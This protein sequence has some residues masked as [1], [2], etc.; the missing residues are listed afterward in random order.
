MDFLED[1]TYDKETYN[2][3]S[4]TIL[5]KLENLE[6]T[7]QQINENN[8]EIKINKIKSLIP[9][10]DKIVGIYDK[11]NIE[12]KNALLKS[13]LVKV[14]YTKTKAREE[15]NLTLEIYPKI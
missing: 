9:K 4:S 3:R 12:Q 14:D 15:N 5:T 13:I 10:I 2:I 8:E 7:K 11:L 6:N 1:G